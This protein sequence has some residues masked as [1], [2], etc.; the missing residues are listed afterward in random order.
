[1]CVYEGEKKDHVMEEIQ[2]R[3]PE[4]YRSVENEED[5]ESGTAQMAWCNAESFI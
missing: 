4:A 3:I 1:M 5:K 2:E